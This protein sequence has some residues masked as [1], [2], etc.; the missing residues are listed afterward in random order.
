MVSVKSERCKPWLVMT[1]S[2]LILHASAS[3]V[4]PT[5]HLPTAQAS[6]FNTSSS[7]HATPMIVSLT[8]TRIAPSSS[9]TAS[10]VPTA[11]VSTTNTTT[12]NTTAKTTTT[13]TT[14]WIPWTEWTLQLQIMIS[15]SFVSFK[16]KVDLWFVFVCCM[17]HHHPPSS[18]PT[19]IITHHHHHH[20]QHPNKW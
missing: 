3:T 9:T 19:I 13:T 5:T 4:N 6:I 18:S 8:P 1:L 20:H 7:A 17:I 15:W 16:R 11:G 14:T 10:F 2:L 12:T